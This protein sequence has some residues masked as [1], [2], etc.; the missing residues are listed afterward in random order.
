[1]R[2][3][4]LGAW[5]FLTHRHHRGQLLGL[6]RTG[7]GRL[8]VLGS[9]RKCLADAVAGGDRAAPFG[10]RAGDARCAARLDGHA[11]V[12]AFSMSMVGTF[13]VRSGILTSVHAFAVDPERGSFILGLLAIY[14]G[15]ALTCSAARGTVREGEQ[16]RPGQPRRR[17][18]GQQRAAHRILGIVLVGTLYP[19]MTEAFGP[20]FRSARPISTR[21]RAL[22]ALPMLL[23]DGCRAAARW[24][25][26]VPHCVVGGR[27]LWPT[28]LLLGTASALAVAAW[29]R[30]GV[31]P[32][33]GL[34]VAVGVARRQPDAA[35]KRNLR[36]T[37]LFTYGMVLAHLG[38]A[39]SLAAWPARAPSPSRSWSRCGWARALRRQAGKCAFDKVQPLAG[40]TGPRCRRIWRLAGAGSRPFSTPKTASSPTP[41]TNTSESALLTR[42]T[43][44]SISC[45]ATGWRMAAGSC[46]SGGSRSSP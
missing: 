14:I 35:A 41:R 11:G 2:P 29:G 21:S 30:I 1:M 24:R 27:M 8:V 38:C 33:L 10:Q 37:P 23:V 42:G 25:R 15:G 4:V 20:R 46:G 12:V 28:G 5:M 6:L 26:D 3:W 19:L 9:G 32:F 31:L 39:V 43:A 34:V 18:G 36:R 17:A 45:W 22:F 16:L 13:L 40:P 44:S 7:L